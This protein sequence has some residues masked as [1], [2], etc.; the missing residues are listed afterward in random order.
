MHLK[1][2]CTRT[3]QELDKRSLEL[4]RLVAEK[5]RC[6]PVLF[7]RAAAILD[8]WRGM[9]P[10]HADAY[11]TEW[12]RLITAGMDE[13]LSVAV[14]DSERAA[15]LR[16]NSP[17]SCLL[18]TRERN[19]V[20]EIGGKVKRSELEHIIRAAAAITNEYEIVVD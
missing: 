17:L 8:R 10:S 12:A 5:I 20:R 6:D 19:E 11:L 9:G 14:E 16:R 2:T 13:C 3:H 15:A 7:D 1:K 4:H 18:S